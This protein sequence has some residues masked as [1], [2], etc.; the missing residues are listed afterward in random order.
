MRGGARRE[1]KFD[2]QVSGV[3]TSDANSRAVYTIQEREKI[4][5]RYLAG[6]ECKSPL[7]LRR[8]KLSNKLSVGSLAVFIDDKPAWRNRRSTLFSLQGPLSSS[9]RGGP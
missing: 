3:Q 7:P 4:I 1:K 2:N 6:T 8:V 9:L 5:F